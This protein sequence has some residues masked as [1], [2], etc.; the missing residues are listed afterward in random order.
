MCMSMCTAIKLEVLVALLTGEV[1]HTG[2]GAIV[3]S[4]TGIVPFYTKPIPFGA[5]HLADVSYCTR[6]TS[7][8][9]APA[10]IELVS[11]DPNLQCESGT[12][13]QGETLG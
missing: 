11:H 2:M 8:G 7:I 10:G 4:S 9:H 13:G 1:F 5:L 3:F 12:A 6:S